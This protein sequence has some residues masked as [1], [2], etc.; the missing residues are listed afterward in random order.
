[1]KS[2]RS[3]A[4]RVLGSRGW[5][6]YSVRERLE[7]SEVP[8]RR[9][10]EV[11]VVGGGPSG[12]VAAYRLRDHDVVVLE[13]ETK[14][15][16]NARSGDWDGTPWPMGA[17]VTYER[18]PA[19]ELYQELGLDPLPAP[20]SY[21]GTV[22]FG[23]RPLNAPLWDGG[24]EE[25]YSRNVVRSIRQARRDLLDMDLEEARSELDQ[26][27]LSDLLT[28]YRPEVRNFFDH[29][30]SWFAGTTDSY[31]AYVGAYLARSQMGAGLGVLYPER[32]SEGG[33]YT[34]PGGL[35][36]ATQALAG[37]VDTAGSGRIWTDSAVLRVEPEGDSVIVRGFRQDRPFAVRA[38]AVIVAI[39]KEVARRIVVE[40]PRS[41]ERAM[42]HFRYVPFLVAGIDASAPIVA[43]VSA[44]RVLDG[45]IATIRRVPADPGRHLYRCEIPLG[46]RDGS[47]ELDREAL[48]DRAGRIVTYLDRISPGAERKIEEVRIWRRGLNWY[49]PIPGMVTDLQPRAAR[50]LDR[51]FFAN[52]DSLGPISEF[53]W[54]MMAADRCVESVRGRLS[55]GSSH[56]SG[57]HRI[58]RSEGEPRV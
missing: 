13:A 57:E 14:I 45:P 18:S 2:A 52:A 38:D 28:S 44:A 48:K 30:L 15:G 17:L 49:V 8:I 26:R 50:P 7:A 56:S 53:G 34:F 12:L 43:G 5:P 41:Q 9:E 33:A 6:A 46:L 36:R 23:D 54:A 47:G 32:T 29:L 4:T 10:V 25:I 21:S 42:K 31:S 11:A 22:Y 16:G 20:N 27:R 1:M 55:S 37:A 24:I 35:G 51:I 39:P 40:L 58:P 19:M 3:V